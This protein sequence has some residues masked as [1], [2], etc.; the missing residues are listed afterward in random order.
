RLMPQEILVAAQS[1]DFNGLE[2]LGLHDCIECGC[3]DVVCPS[4]IVLTERFREA[5]REYAKHERQL[6][7]SAEAEERYRH[8]ERRLAEAERHSRE[9]QD[10]LRA[11]VHADDE[12]RRRA[13][14]AAVERAK[15]R[16]QREES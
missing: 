14:E 12:A 11:E 2:M 5:K 16:R 7:L 10:A 8:R 15:R 4:H 3:C 13:I 1:R 9:A 6:E